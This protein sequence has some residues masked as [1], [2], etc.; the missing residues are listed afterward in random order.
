MSQSLLARLSPLW[1]REYRRDKLSGDMTAG[2]I[3]TVMLIPQS[4]AYAMLAGLPLEVGI[5]ASIAPLIVYAIFGTSMTLAV[6]PVAVASLM[7]A[8]ALAPLATPGSPEYV[9]MA[10]QLAMISGVMLFLFGVLRLGAVAHFLSHPVIS[11]FISG[12]AVL[13]AISQVKH[14]IGISFPGRGVWENLVGLASGVDR[15]N[16]ATAALGLVSLIFLWWARGGLPKLLQRLGIKD[17]LASTLSKL[18]PMLAVVLTTLTV[19][20]AGLDAIGVK[21]VGEVPA[22]LPSLAWAALDWSN[23]SILWGPALLIGLVGFVESISVAQSL[24]IKRKQR[25]TPDN[26]LLG[27]GAANMASALSGGFPVTGGFARSVVNF[28][29]G[30]QTPLAGVISAI[31]MGLVLVGFTDWFEK[32]PQA[33]LAA[34]IIVAVTSLIDLTTLRRAWKYDRA[35]AVALMVTALGVIALGVEI[36]VLL[37]VALSLGVVIWRSSHPHMAI[38]GRVPGTEHF[39]NVARHKVETAPDALA[40]RIDENLFFANA[41]T[42]EARLQSMVAKAGDSTRK[43]LLILSA[44]NQIDSTAVEMLEEFEHS[45][46]S[47]G[48]ELWFAEVKGPVAD[49]LNKSELGSKMQ[50]RTA[51]S[52]NDLMGAWIKA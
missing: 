39:R 1:L 34:T 7:T 38:V 42:V 41:Q 17:S 49:R 12:S 31:L 21:V 29:A 28:A 9:A 22:G 2:F 30:A 13:I 11:G 44:V 51:L 35:D 24:A 26:E 6:G 45:L 46:A 32:L 14:V 16:V 50:S 19:S 10:A 43:V 23:V 15:I 20:F 52:T 5:Y 3:V 4:L 47:Q 25:I 36:G 40:I 18:A 37:G 48:K 8:S 33:V 27:L